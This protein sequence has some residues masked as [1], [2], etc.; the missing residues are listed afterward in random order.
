MPTSEPSREGA[1]CHIQAPRPTVR[2]D[3]HGVVLA[4]EIEGYS[5]PTVLEVTVPDKPMP[6]FGRALDDQPLPWLAG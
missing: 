1:R 6:S 2:V 5:A 4:V 3:E